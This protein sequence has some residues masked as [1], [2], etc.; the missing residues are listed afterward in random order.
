MR[1]STNISIINLLIC[2]ALRNCEGKTFFIEKFP[3]CMACDFV[4]YETFGSL[5]QMLLELPVGQ[6]RNK[7]QTFL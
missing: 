1:I 6:K 4:V 3:K 5:T 7:R 2:I